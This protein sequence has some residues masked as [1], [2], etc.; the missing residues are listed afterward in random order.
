MQ[1]ASAGHPLPTRYCVPFLTNVSGPE[2]M[3][4]SPALYSGTEFLTYSFRARLEA[5]VRQP[6]ETHVRT[7]STPE[8]AR[9][10]AER[11]DEARDRSEGRSTSHRRLPRCSWGLL[12]DGD[13]EEEDEEEEEED[14]GVS[15]SRA[16]ACKGTMPGPPASMKTRFGAGS[17]LP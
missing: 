7:E 8:R 11:E 17:A 1:I 16:I 5:P 13:D 4:Q 14:G 3:A 15:R 2:T 12:E 10:S 9:T 6:G